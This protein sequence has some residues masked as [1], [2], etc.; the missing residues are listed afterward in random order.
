MY[1][2][3]MWMR[4]KYC[5]SRGGHESLWTAH[6]FMDKDLRLLQRKIQSR[7][8][9]QRRI[10]RALACRDGPDGIGRQVMQTAGADSWCRQLVQ[11]AGA[12]SWN[13]AG[14]ATERMGRCI[15]VKPVDC[16]TVYVLEAIDTDIVEAAGSGWDGKPHGRIGKHGRQTGGQTEEEAGRESRR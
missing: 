8:S 2:A 11:T 3:G 13:Q 12:D 16:F 7:D 15:K 14:G 5:V 6:A 4:Q 10:K 9:T 1:L